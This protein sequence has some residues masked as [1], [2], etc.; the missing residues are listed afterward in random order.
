MNL[1]AEA[2]GRMEFR[3][4][5]KSIRGPK[6]TDRLFCFAAMEHDLRSAGVEICSLGTSDRERSQR[7]SVLPLERRVVGLT[8]AVVPM[9][10]HT[11]TIRLLASSS[12]LQLQSSLNQLMAR[13]PRFPN[14]PERLSTE[15]NY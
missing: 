4:P 7:S 2:H 8:H 9:V 14:F 5:R 13:C 12:E 3:L 6:L 10:N 15:F 11:R 1:A